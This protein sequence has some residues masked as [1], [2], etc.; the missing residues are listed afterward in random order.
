MVTDNIETQSRYI[1]PNLMVEA[2]RTAKPQRSA[3]NYQGLPLIAV[4]YM[5]SKNEI[6]S[7][8]LPIQYDNDNEVIQIA[9]KRVPVSEATRYLS[10][11]AAKYRADDMASLLQ[12]GGEVAF[13]FDQIQD[14]A[15]NNQFYAV[16]LGGSAATRQQ[17][18]ANKY[19]LE[20]TDPNYYQSPTE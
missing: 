14:D 20:N 17:S 11:S 16:E 19:F 4:P 9:G 6:K 1:D 8:M 13:S 18:L 7:V 15:N 12:D 3:S 5:N 2:M 10:A